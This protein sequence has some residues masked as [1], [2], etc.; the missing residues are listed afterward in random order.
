MEPDVYKFLENIMVFG[1]I[2]SHH[3]VPLLQEQFDV[4]EEK[5]KNC[6]EEFRISIMTL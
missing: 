5:A 2:K 6:I 3:L 4:T 1:T